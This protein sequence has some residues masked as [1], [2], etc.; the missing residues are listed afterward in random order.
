M[1]P[2]PIVWQRLV[3]HDGETCHRCDATR[4][5]L[6]RAVAVLEPVLR[7]LGILPEL[8]FR[9]LD[10][11]SFAGDPDQSN[12]IWIDGVAIEV[13]LAATVGHSPCC[14][15]CGGADCRTLALDGAAFETIP[16]QLILKA[17]LRAA[18]E[19]LSLV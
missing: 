16:A 8:E 4:L 17:A 11:C 6:E 3:D 5:E 13:W 10:E 18:A 15:V 12:R 1:R 2:L 9:E 19:L 14:A 7:P